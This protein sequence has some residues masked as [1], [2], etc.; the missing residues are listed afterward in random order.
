MMVDNLPKINIPEIAGKYTF[1]SGTLMFES[2]E[3]DREIGVSRDD[4]YAFIEEFRIKYPNFLYY[5]IRFV[6]GQQKI[7]LDFCYA[8]NRGET[9]EAKME[10]FNLFYQ[11]GL[12][13][14]LY[15]TFGSAFAGFDVSFGSRGVFVNTDLLNL[16]QN[17]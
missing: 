10:N 14:E 17:K 8:V 15:K 1:C 6:N 7:H 3:K 9:Q 11:K 12:K 13:N 5:A 2:S 16:N 4:L